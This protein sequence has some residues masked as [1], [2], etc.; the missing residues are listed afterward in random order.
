MI[1]L[2]L[3]DDAGARRYLGRALAINPNF[4]IQHADEAAET[5]AS[6]GSGR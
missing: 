6:L 1:R 5:L 3:G 2:G 4:S